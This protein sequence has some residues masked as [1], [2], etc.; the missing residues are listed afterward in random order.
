VPV[1]ESPSKPMTTTEE[2]INT[3]LN[4]L[5]EIKTNNYKFEDTNLQNSLYNSDLKV[6]NVITSS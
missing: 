3:S 1:K 5:F 6:E 4:S 2:K